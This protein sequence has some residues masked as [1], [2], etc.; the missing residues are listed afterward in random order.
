MGSDVYLCGGLR[1]IFA[2]IALMLASGIAGAQE[3]EMPEPT[4]NKDVLFEKFNCLAKKI[5][6]LEETVRKIAPFVNAG[7]AVVAFDRNRNNESVCPTGWAFFKPAD[8]RFVVGAGEH[9]NSGLSKYPSYIEDVEDEDEML[10]SVGGEE[11]HTLIVAEM[12]S[13]RHQMNVHHP[14][15]DNVDGPYAITRQTSDGEYTGYEGGGEAHNNNATFRGTI[16]L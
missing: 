14:A 15:V 5:Q 4:A 3:C 11:K 16:F 12:P 10:D 7:G 6:K 2:S 1:T 8:G 13:H 9:A